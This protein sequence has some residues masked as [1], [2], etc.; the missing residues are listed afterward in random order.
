[1]GRLCVAWPLIDLCGSLVGPMGQVEELKRAA[2]LLG[3]VISN[4]RQRLQC[5]C[6]NHGSKPHAVTYES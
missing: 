4:M 5:S 3:S 6:M 2:L 1:M